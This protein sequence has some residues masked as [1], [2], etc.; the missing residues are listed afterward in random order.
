MKLSG[1]QHTERSLLTSILLSFLCIAALEIVLPVFRISVLASS[2]TTVAIDPQIR[3]ANPG[4]SFTIN[5]TVTNVTDLTSWG[6][7]VGFPRGLLETIKENITEGPFLKLGGSTSFTAKVFSNYIDVGCVLPGATAGVSG[8]GTLASATFK[9]RTTGNTT[10]DLYNVG[11]L[12]SGGLVIEDWD[13]KDSPDDGYFYTTMP[14]AGYSY[15]PHPIDYPGHP[16]VNETVTFNAT[17]SYDPDDLYESSPGGIVNYS[18]DFGDNS[19]GTGLFVNHTYSATGSYRVTLN[20]TDDD[21]ELDSI[22]HPIIGTT[23]NVLLHDI[24]VIGGVVT[25]PEVSLGGSF[26]INVTVLNQGSDTESLNVTVYANMAPVTTK[27][28]EYYEYPPPW[29]VPQHHTSLESEENATTTIIWDTTG[30]PTGTYAISVKGFLVKQVKGKWQS[31][32]ELEREKDMLD[33]GMFLGNVTIVGALRHD[34]AVT[35]LKVSPTSLEFDEWASIEVLIKN[36][37]TVS[38]QFNVTEIIEYGLERTESKPIA[39]SNKTIHAGTT[40]RLARTWFKG[41]T[42]TKE[43]TYNITMEVQLVNKT[44]LEPPSYEDTNS[45][46]NVLRKEV[47]VYLKPIAS[48]T[49]SPTS[50]SVDEAVTFNATK[51]YNPGIPEGIIE[52]YTWDFGDGTSVEKTSP[53][54]THVY[55]LSGRYTVNLTVTDDSDQ[56]RSKQ[57]AVTVPSGMAH[58]LMSLRFS[59]SVVMPG[60]SV[61]VN[62]TARNVGYLEEAFNLTAY[63]DENEIGTEANIT[64]ECGA[65]T[66]LTFS[67]DT[68]GVPH[69]Y[70]TIKTVASKRIDGLLENTCIGGTVAIGMGGVSPD[71]TSNI[72][73]SASPPSLNIG[74]S[75]IISGSISPVSAGAKVVI[76]FRLREAKT[77]SNVTVITDPNG[78]YEFTWE[79][80]KIGLYALRS[81]LLGEGTTLLGE[82]EIEVMVVNESASPNIFFYTTIGLAVASGLASV[83]MGMIVFY[84]VRSGKVKGG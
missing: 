28:F 68:T 39:W 44:T 9:V 6:F 69:G 80:Q 41:T 60:E 57:T 66:T 25:P 26:S 51:S 13:K 10:L 55:R 47:N 4:G 29:Y 12:D 7:R 27:L 38:E 82:S 84:L 64:L 78:N 15:A 21:G 23:I 37:G 73:I 61:S 30:I 24:A 48:F 35:G 79:P 2:G 3:S 16:I 11:L 43:G 77:W 63:Y 67:W 53:I 75:T 70:Y 72:T 71:L 59:P 31:K 46:D 20:V 17:E 40:L 8:N 42:A 34:L 74:E 18:W 5:V 62:V 54:A 22:D 1:L 56:K 83:I 19:T 36:K 45:T 14:V 33:N 32:P 52:K 65:D 49:Y 50:P 58:I 81:A 76:H